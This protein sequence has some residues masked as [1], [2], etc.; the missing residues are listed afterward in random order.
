[1]PSP[2]RSQFVA[3]NKLLRRSGWLVAG[4]EPDKRADL[5]M[6]RLTLNALRFLDEAR[7]SGGIHAGSMLR[8]PFPVALTP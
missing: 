3:T 8:H 2:C 1:M 7:V 6:S 4:E 5:Y